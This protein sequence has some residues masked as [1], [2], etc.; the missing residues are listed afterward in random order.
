MSLPCCIETCKQTS[1]I[2]C[3]SCKKTYCPEHLK[4]H[5][6]KLYLKF[7]PLID[8][9]KNLSNRC[10]LL[11]K[12]KL[13]NEYYQKLDKW[14]DDS[15]KTIDRLYEQ[16]REELNKDWSQKLIKPQKDL[17]QINSK[18]NEF[19]RQ[20]KTTHEDIDQSIERL[21]YI[22]K[23]IKDLEE[24][25]IQIDLNPLLINQNLK[26][27]LENFDIFNLSLS[28]RIIDCFS[29]SSFAFSQNNQNLLIYENNKL[30]LFDQDLISI[31]QLS[32]KN[33]QIYDICWINKLN[34]FILITDKGFIYLINQNPLAFTLIKSIKQ[35]KWWSLTSSDKYLFLSTYGTDTNIFQFDILSSFDFI[36]RW[37]SPQT[38]QQH[39]YIH[40]INYTNDTI[41]LIIG[42][43]LNKTVRIELRSSITLTQIWT[44]LI[45]INH[46]SYQ[47]KIHSC[48]LNYDEWIIILENTS[49][50]Y[51]ITKDG[52]L[53]TIY[54]Y[55]QPVWNA[56]LFN[57]NLLAIRT[58]NN[59]FFHRI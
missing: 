4:E 10:S 14:R 6:D 7:D 28:Y 1:S 27:K 18:I 44:I 16:K 9:I 35:E 51:H 26:S 30:N 11:D 33:G 52:K 22:D 39:E 58:K 34:Q 48:L 17:D 46:L 24:K 54:Q 55:Q 47:S 43:S 13:I 3:Y 8:E 20:Q 12:N 5:D 50:I 38:C 40:N 32:W 15:H 41:I 42:D 23:Q 29:Q 53:K 2:L 19:I 37:R 21:R 31:Q 45:D 59:I 36:K 25:G 56:L 49:D 57:Y